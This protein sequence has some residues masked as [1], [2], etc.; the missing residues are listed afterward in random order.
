MGKRRILFI[1]FL[2]INNI[3]LFSLDSREILIVYQHSRR[4]SHNTISIKMD[5]VSK[6]ITVE[7]YQLACNRI[8]KQYNN[9]ISIDEK[10]FDS[11]YERL[12]KIKYTDI[13]DK[14]IDGLDG[15]SIQIKIGSSLNYLTVNIWSPNYDF[16][17]RGTNELLTVL[18]EIFTKIGLENRMN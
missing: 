12:M 11:I 17:K 2:F 8:E 5:S 13:I 1:I 9:T 18:I 16:E 7:T 4:I 15:Y 6:E 14:A 10:Y 3:L